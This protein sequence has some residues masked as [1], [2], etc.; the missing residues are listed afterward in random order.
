M[1][2]PREMLWP[3]LLLLLL[4][5]AGCVPPNNVP[6][7]PNRDPAPLLTDRLEVEAARAGVF[8]VKDGQREAVPVSPERVIL[9]P[10]QGLAVDDDG[11]AILYFNDLLNVE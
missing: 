6:L 10:G 1:L 4:L 11:R 5:V 7:G 8:L 9:E 2:I 3:I